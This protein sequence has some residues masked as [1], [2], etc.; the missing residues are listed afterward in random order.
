MQK[1]TGIGDETILSMQGVLLTFTQIKGDVFKDATEAILNISVALG[2][3]LQQSAIQVG[4]ALNDPAKGVSAL[5]RVGIQFTDEQKAMIKQLD[6]TN[7]TAKAQAIILKELELQFGGTASNVSSTSISLKR[8]SSAF[9]DLMES[10]GG[11]LAPLLDNLII[12]TTELVEGLNETP[13]GGFTDLFVDLVNQ[14]TRK[15]IAFQNHLGKVMDQ[16]VL[17]IMKEIGFVGEDVNNVV[18]G[19]ESSFL[20]ATGMIKELK[21]V[22]AI[23]L[24]SDA[25]KAKV[26]EFGEALRENPGKAI[27]MINDELRDLDLQAPEVTFFDDFI[28]LIQQ[29]NQEKNIEDFITKTALTFNNQFGKFDEL[30]GLATANDQNQDV[31]GLRNFFLKALAGRY[32]KS[33]RNK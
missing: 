25:N 13:E 19:V 10:G 24:F 7:Q 5:Q 1:L 4:K 29:E 32:F 11:K 12:L 22:P 17:S 6:K 20:G 21:T 3:D 16:K 26:I 31:L 30:I 27:N 23:S 15:T 2:Q 18:I 9:G 8:L 14:E 28:Q 33:K